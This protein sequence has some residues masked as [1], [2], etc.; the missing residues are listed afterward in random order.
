MSFESSPRVAVREQVLTLGAVRAPA[1]TVAGYSHWAS[2]NRERECHNARTL[3]VLPGLT[4][5]TPFMAGDQVVTLS[6]SLSRV[7]LDGGC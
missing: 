4:F 6:R 5:I 7:E 3:P 1:L 2:Q